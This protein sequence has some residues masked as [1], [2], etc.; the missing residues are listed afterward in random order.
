MVQIGEPRVIARAYHKLNFGQLPHGAPAETRCRW[1]NDVIVD[2][3]FENAVGERVTSV[4]QED[5][6]SMC[7]EVT[8]AEDLTNPVFAATLRTE[9]GHT[10]IVARSDGGGKRE[11]ILRGRQTR[12]SRGSDYPTG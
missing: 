12:R 1:W 6:L 8:I 9:L 5:G 3:W 10:I 11:R 7:F 4:N 2:A